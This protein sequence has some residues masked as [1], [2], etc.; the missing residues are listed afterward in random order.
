MYIQADQTAKNASNILQPILQNNEFTYNFTPILTGG[1]IPNFEF[2]SKNVLFRQN[3]FFLPNKEA[4]FQ[5]FYDNNVPLVF[6]Y[7]PIT[8]KITN[9]SQWESL[10]A[11]IKIMGGELVILT[12][13]DKNYFTRS[14][15]ERSKLTIISD[16]NF[17][18]AEGLGLYDNFNPL[19]DWISGIEENIPLPA[20][21]IT[22]PTGD[23]KAHHI[24]YQFKTLKTNLEEISFVRKLLTTIYNLA[25]DRSQN[26]DYAIAL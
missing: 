14:I 19:T 13:A 23:I 24:D 7:W 6:A 3:S 4:S 26:L 16:K 11:D 9:V 2:K 5:D 18:I 1:K 21:Y 15:R 25:Q 17:S 8:Q 12:N 10:A 22:T 20:F